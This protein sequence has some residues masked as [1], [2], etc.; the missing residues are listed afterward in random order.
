MSSEFLLDYL[1][2]FYTKD[3]QDANGGSLLLPIFDLYKTLYDDCLY[4]TIQIRQEMSFGKC[5]FYIHE[6]H[7]TIDTTIGNK[8]TAGGHTGYKVDPEIVWIDTPYLDANMTIPLGAVNVYYDSHNNIKFVVFQSTT[9]FANTQTCVF[10][11][12]CYKDKKLLS[13]VY[14]QLLDYHEDVLNVN[15][16]N[17]VFQL[18]FVAITTR[19]AQYRQ[20]LLALM[21]GRTMGPTIKV[22][23]NAIAMFLLYTFS[24]VDGTV[25]GLSSTSITIESSTDQKLYAYTVTSPAPGLAI[26]SMVSKYD[27]LENVNFLLY[28]MFSN[29]ARF[30]Q[31][32]L[33]Y[34]PEMNLLELLKIDLTKDEKYAYLNYDSS[35]N[36][37]NNS[38]GWD[39]GSGPAPAYSG[40]T[41]YSPASVSPVTRFVGG[42]TPWLDDRF[43]NIGQSIPA[44][45]YEMFRNVMILEFTNHFVNDISYIFNKIKPTYI[46]LLSTTSGHVVFENRTSPPE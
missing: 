31:T 17:Q 38:L 22:M 42:S 21:Y 3:F 40:G 2:S 27:C 44:P 16:H 43:N 5:P 25:R 30:T 26:G 23:N 19:Y 15:N 45:V 13:K 18:D 6:T 46:K 4:R 39:M 20:R 33:S 7:I 37:D 9:N 24:T 28:D 41:A 34:E 8:Y 36:W 29:P 10:V 35:I 14:G 1:P 11:R 12:S 32:L